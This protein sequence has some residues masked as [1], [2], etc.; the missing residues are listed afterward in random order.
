M[1]MQYIPYLLLGM[2][3]NFNQELSETVFFFCSVPFRNITTQYISSVLLSW[4]LMCDDC[5]LIAI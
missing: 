5:S 2:N 1:N 4:C 3:I